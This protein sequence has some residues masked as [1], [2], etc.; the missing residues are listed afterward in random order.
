MQ[1]S[2]ASFSQQGKRPKNEDFV[3][4]NSY[5]EQYAWMGIA[6]D[7]MGGHSYGEIASHVVAETISQFWEQHLKEPDSADKVKQACQDASE[8]FRVTADNM[9]HVDMGT[10]MVMASIQNKLLTIAHIGDSRCYIFRKDQGCIFQTQDHLEVNGGRTYIAKCFFTDHPSVAVPD[11]HQE[12]LQLGD[13]I[14]LCTD[15]L[16]KSIAPNLLKKFMSDPNTPDELLEIFDS[17]CAKLAH[18]NYSAIILEV[19]EL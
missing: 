14:L 16:Y 13:K 6:C 17:R 18:D 12:E 19:V 3:L 15:G 1:I 2:Y 11:I 4:L 8:R 7:G 10:T 9:N 5:P